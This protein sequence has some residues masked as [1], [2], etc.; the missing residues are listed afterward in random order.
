MSDGLVPF[1]AKDEGAAFLPAKVI[2][3]GKQI[4]GAWVALRTKHAHETL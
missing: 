3:N 4:V 1:L 2:D